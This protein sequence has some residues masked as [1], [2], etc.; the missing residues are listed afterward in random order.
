MQP[1]VKDRLIEKERVDVV[2]TVAHK[3]KNIDKI[4]EWA[5]AHKRKTGS[6]IANP[7]FMMVV[8]VPNVGKSSLINALTMK[9]GK[10][11]ENKKKKNKVGAHPGV[12]RHIHQVCRLPFVASR[13]TETLI[14]LIISFSHIH[15]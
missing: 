9:Y 13:A 14:D 15:R 2:F 7:L 1:R 8:G 10:G 5:R 11:L 3:Q 6:P 4:V 12:T